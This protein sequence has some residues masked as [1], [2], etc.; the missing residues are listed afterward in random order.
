VL[1]VLGGRDVLVAG[2]AAAILWVT[3]LLVTLL[4]LALSLVL[5]VLLP[6]ASSYFKIVFYWLVAGHG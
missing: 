5:S 1:Y 2:S 3:L 4:L 6:M